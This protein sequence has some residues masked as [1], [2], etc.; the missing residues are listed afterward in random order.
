MKKNLLI[1]LCLLLWP[2]A[3]ITAEKNNLGENITTLQSL[4]GLGSIELKKSISSYSLVLPLSQRIAPANRILHLDFSSSI[5]LLKNRSQLAVLVNGIVITQIALD[6]KNPSMKKDISIPSEYLINGYNHVEF[7]AVQHYTDS[8]EDPTAPELWTQINGEKSYFKFDYNRQPQNYTL[9]NLDHLFDKRLPD[10]EVTIVTAYEKFND[11]RLQLGSLIA[12]GVALHLDYVTPTFRLATASS[13]TEKIKRKVPLKDRSYALSPL[14]QSGM[15]GDVVLIGTR[16]EL[17]PYI[18]TAQ[19]QKI[20]G[21]YLGVVPAKNP[22][23]QVVIVSGTTKEEVMLAAKSFAFT[24]ES[25]PDDKSM[26][27]TSLDIPAIGDKK[28]PLTLQPASIY[29][30]ED[31]G[32]NTQ[33]LTTRPVSLQV[34]MPPDLLRNDSANVRFKFNLS[35]GAALR[36]DSVLNIY[37]NDAFEKAIRLDDKNGARYNGYEIN[38]PFANFTP[39][40]NT[41][42]FEPVMPPLVTGSSGDCSLVQYQNSQLTLFAESTIELPKADRY[43]ALPNFE[44]FQR[45][46]FPFTELAYGVNI[47]IVLRDHQS[48]TILSAWQLIAKMTQMNKA[49]LHNAKLSFDSITG[50]DLF[51]IGERKAL[52][53]DDLINAPMKLGGTIQASSIVAKES[54]SNSRGFFTSLF[55][56]TPPAILEQRVVGINFNASLGR[57]A[58]MIGYPSSKDDDR[59]VILITNESADQLYNSVK[60][61]VAPKIWNNLKGNVAVWD[62]TSEKG[63][64]FTQQV[65]EIFH[66]GEMSIHNQ[67]AYHFSEHLNQWLIFIISLPLLLAWLGHRWLN[68][69]KAKQ[70]NNVQE[71]KS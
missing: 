68:S 29:H 56:S 16:S 5:A 46:G 36:Q 17:E 21:A 25:L 50:R 23:Y 33:T 3:A 28:L 40:L 54:E 1:T 34:M 63:I 39:G 69:Y 41:I 12:Q 70:Q 13:L 19:A 66:R 32:F 45:T 26:I 6:P 65:G 14:D 37:L 2:I 71:F 20:S 44:L 67:L 30:F 9:A 51:I 49:P 62:A 55:T 27:I 48:Q 8:C 52:L 4:T 31:L 59:M 38:I 53:P 7:R 42:S 64:V 58:V 43:V 18:T 47:G 24:R 60:A 11:E 15:K 61:L 10:Y 57:Q 35:Y 22:D